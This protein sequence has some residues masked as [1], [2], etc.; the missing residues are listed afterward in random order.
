MYFSSEHLLTISAIVNL[1]F[2]SFG[3]TV[4]VIELKTSYILKMYSTTGQ[5]LCPYV[6]S[7]L[8]SLIEGVDTVVGGILVTGKL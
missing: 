4:L 2:L 6:Y 8:D 7:Y 1:P 5:H 3:W